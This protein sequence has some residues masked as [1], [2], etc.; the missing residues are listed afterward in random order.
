MRRVITGL[1]YT[2][3][4]GTHFSLSVQHELSRGERVHMSPHTDLNRGVVC[5]CVCL[6]LSV[7]IC[8]ICRGGV[9]CACVTACLC[10]FMCLFVCVYVYVFV[11]MCMF[12][13]ICVCVYMYG[14]LCVNSG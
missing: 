8:S 4:T 11:C 2:Q 1:S 5:L 9:N 6:Y 10:V 7:C 13:C 14:C 3:T 12:F